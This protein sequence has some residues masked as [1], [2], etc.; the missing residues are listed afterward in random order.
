M[1]SNNRYQGTYSARSG[2]I[3]HSQSTTLEVTRTCSNGSVSFYRQVSSEAS[4]DYLRFYIDD[5]LQGSWSGTQGWS[6]VRY[7]VTA[8]THTFKWT[9]SKDASVNTNS[10]AAWI[11]QISFPATDPTIVLR[12]PVADTLYRCAVDLPLGGIYWR[13]KSNLLDV[14]SARDTFEVVADSVPYLYRFDGDTVNT[15]TPTL[16]WRSVPG[17]TSYTIMLDN[18]RD[19]SSPLL[20]IIPIADTLYTPVV[21]LNSGTYYWKVCNNRNGTYADPDHFVVPP[22][23]ATGVVLSQESAYGL[24]LL[25]RNGGLQVSFSTVAG[26]RPE[27]Y[28]YR[29]DGRLVHHMTMPNSTGVVDIGAAARLPAGSYIA[30]MRA[31]DAVFTRK[32]LLIK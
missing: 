30:I 3:S 4:Y 17:A 27:L 13:V 1:T 6:Q 7:S 16:R 18:S 10:D 24:R 12:S 19:F 23:V 9:Y 29:Q 26:Q 28:V 5:V 15:C 2:A 25:N 31:G 20:L 21:A 14:Y 11:D 8:G 22:S 32:A